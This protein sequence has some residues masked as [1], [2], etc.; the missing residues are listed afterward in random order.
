MGLWH[1]ANWTFLVW[2][3]YHFLFICINRLIAPLTRNLNTIIAW[4]GGLIFTIPAMMLAWVPFRAQSVSDVV[5][6]WF[7]IFDLKSYTQLSMRENTYLV[8][9]M[10]FCGFF[11]TYFLKKK[12]FNKFQSKLFSEKIFNCFLIGFIIFFVIIFFR[13]NNQF[14]YFQF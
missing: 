10:I 9:F 7:K 12:I 13:S 4:W 8:T 1:G 5:I 11:I 3:I 2:G 6:M 14:I